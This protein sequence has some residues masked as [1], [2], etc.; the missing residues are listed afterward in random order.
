[1]IA[2]LERSHL[3]IHLFDEMTGREIE[4]LDGQY[5]P[6]RQ[7]EL[8]MRLSKFKL[9]WVPR[10]VSLPDIKDEKHRQFLMGLETTPHSHAKFSFNREEPPHEVIVQAV[11]ECRESFEQS[12]TLKRISASALVD[13]HFRDLAYATELYPLLEKFNVTF[14]VNPA[15]DEPRQN[16]NG[17]AKLLK[18]VTRLIIVFGNAGKEW[19]KNRVLEAVKMS[20]EEEGQLKPCGIY[21]APPHSLSTDGKFEFGQLPVYQFDRPN[22]DGAMASWLAET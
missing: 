20:L 21:F 9:I 10:S 19:T 18:Q 3:S 11:L 14:F 16:M 13:A 2:E 22:L 15:G 6:Q 7:V 17:L 12:K 8:A 1:V 5:Y 4:D